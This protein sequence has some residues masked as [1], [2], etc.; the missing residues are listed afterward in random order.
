MAIESLTYN[1]P[2]S[3]KLEMLHQMLKTVENKFSLLLPHQDSLLLCPALV[4]HTVTA[5]RK[6][7]QK[8][9]W[10]Q[11]RPSKYVSLPL[12]KRTCKGKMGE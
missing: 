8:Y 5:A 9:R 2:D 12:H 4:A 7:S 1:Y 3:G 6:I 10:L 11:L